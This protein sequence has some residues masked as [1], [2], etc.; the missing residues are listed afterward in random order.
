MEPD[1]NDLMQDCIVAIA[2]AVDI[3]V[4][5]MVSDTMYQQITRI[6][7]KLYHLKHS[8]PHENQH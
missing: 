6:E 5:H 7:I 2:Q 3:T 8:Q 1:I 4:L